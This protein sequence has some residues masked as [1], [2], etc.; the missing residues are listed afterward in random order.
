[1]ADATALTT[2]PSPAMTIRQRLQLFTWPV[3]F[4]A[5]LTSVAMFNWGYDTLVFSGVVAMKH[6]N[7]KFG[8]CHTSLTTGLPVC[9]IPGSTVSIMNAA[10]FAGKLVGI[11]MAAPLAQR[12]GRKPIFLVVVCTSW[13]GVILQI[14][15]TTVAQFTVGR[16]VCYSMTG[17]CAPVIPAYVAEVAPAELRGMLVSLMHLQIVLGNII[18]SV[19]NTRTSKIDS[20][21][22]WLIPIGLQFVMPSVMAAGYPLLVESPR[23]L[24]SENRTD[25]AI[26][27]L[28]RLRGS[29]V[30]ES[31]IASEA[32]LLVTANTNQSK[33]RWSEVLSGTNRRRTLIGILALVGQQI[34]GQVF[35]LQ[36][37]VLFYQKQGY[38]NSF[39]LLAGGLVVSLVVSIFTTF[40]VDHFGRRPLLI[41]GGIGQAVFLLLIGAV[42][43]PLGV[44]RTVLNLQVAGFYLWAIAYCLSWAPLSYVILAE[45]SPTR[46]VEKTNLIATSVNVVVAFAVSLSAPYLLYEEYANLGGKVGY[47]YGSFAL[48]L[49]VLAFFFV[50]EMKGRTL[51]EIEVLFADRVPTRKFKG[52]HVDVASLK[53]GDSV[54]DSA[55]QGPAVDQKRD[56]VVVETKKGDGQV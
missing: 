5:I 13:V 10:P 32:D 33:G 24:V 17:I 55:R 9:E 46:L 41:T 37:G 45:A 42:S 14:T 53:I 18:A 25:C 35:V 7:I 16:V 38:T 48:M 34:T 31:D 56:E 4:L 51:E 52:T 8:Q 36:Y 6:F 50:P 3:G 47:I 49:A 22:S 1:M 27:A 15:A 11:W 28:R 21:S 43:T 12:I 30:S 39:E 19:I 54:A 40:V 20:N 23:W 29:T 26:A 2:G 44:T